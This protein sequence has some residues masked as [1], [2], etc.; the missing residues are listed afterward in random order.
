MASLSEVATRFQLLGKTFLIEIIGLRENS[1]PLAEEQKAEKQ[2]LIQTHAVKKAET[3]DY[4]LIIS[5][6]FNRVLL[7]YL[8]PRCEF[9]ERKAQDLLRLLWPGNN[10][11]VF[12]IVRFN[13]LV[14]RRLS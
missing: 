13:Y 7:F 2:E 12:Y 3:V 11:R 6:S 4:Y 10:D 5:A 9:S 1:Y 8:L 14:R